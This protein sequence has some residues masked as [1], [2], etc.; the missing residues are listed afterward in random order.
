MSVGSVG[1]TLARVGGN[2]LTGT[3]RRESHSS[4]QIEVAIT[5][6]R[7]SR[8]VPVRRAY[9]SKPTGLRRATFSA[10]VCD[11][12][13]PTP[14]PPRLTCLADSLSLAWRTSLAHMASPNGTV[15]PPAPNFAQLPLPPGMTLDQYEETQGKL[16]ALLSFLRTCCSL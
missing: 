6:V 9:E 1:H 3:W 7:P 11:C 13:S 10:Q 4:A 2:P 8:A 12:W 5:T 14:H 15:A 16:G